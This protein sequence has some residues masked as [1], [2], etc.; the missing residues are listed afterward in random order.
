MQQVFIIAK[1]ST[2]FGQFM[3]EMSAF[4]LYGEEF[5]KKKKELE[6]LKREIINLKK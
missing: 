3:G 4:S 5:E 1:S 6:A 2:R